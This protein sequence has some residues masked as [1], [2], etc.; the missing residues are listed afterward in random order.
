MQN[1]IYTYYVYCIKLKIAKNL[2]NVSKSSCERITIVKNKM[3]Q[4]SIR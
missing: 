4:K 2:A 1:Y 3:K